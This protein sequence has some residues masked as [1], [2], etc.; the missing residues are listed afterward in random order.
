MAIATGTATTSLSRAP[1]RAPKAL[2]RNS[3]RENCLT[4]KAR[5]PYL[6]GYLRALA[7]HSFDRSEPVCLVYCCL[8]CG[9][10]KIRRYC[11]AHRPYPVG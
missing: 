3:R 9:A 5:R 8:R 1:A 4:R 7:L 6:A 11:S 2:A 10:V